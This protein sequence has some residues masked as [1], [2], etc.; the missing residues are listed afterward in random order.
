MINKNFL[1][2]ILFVL[3]KSLNLTIGLKSTNLCIIKQQK[4]LCKGYYDKNQ[5]YKTKCDLIKCF[6]LFSY[7][8]KSNICA[9]NLTECIEYN[10]MNSHLYISEKKSKLAMLAL[11]EKSSK[12]KLINRQM[13][14]CKNVNYKFN[15]N[16]FCLSGKNCRQI[17]CYKYHRMIVGIDC[18]CPI[19]QSF[20]C[21]NFCTTDSISCD[22]FNNNLIKNKE[23]FS[24]IKQCGNDNVSIYKN[25]YQ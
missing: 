19:K 25:I 2:I 23:H 14:D 15:S 13:L 7:E 4:Q 17:Y 18:K 21:G 9:N 6:G 22:Y 20:K 16:D 1:I 8:C 24:K 12:L 11:K 10:K 3:L 5:I